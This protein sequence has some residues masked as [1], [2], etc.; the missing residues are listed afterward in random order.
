[1][2]T[3]QGVT[4]VRISDFRRFFT[5]G[6]FLYKKEQ[7]YQMFIEEQRCY[8]AFGNKSDALMFVDNEREF[9]L[10]RILCQWLENPDKEITVST[11]DK[12]VLYVP[13][14]NGEKVLFQLNRL[15]PYINEAKKQNRLTK[16]SI[17]GLTVLYLLLGANEQD[18]DIPVVY[19]LQ[20]VGLQLKDFN[21]CWD[22]VDIEKGDG[23]M[24]PLHRRIFV[25]ANPQKPITVTWGI[26]N[27]VLQP[28][29][30]LI[31]L[32]YGNACHVLL[33]GKITSYQN[34][35]SLRLTADVETKRTRM[36]VHT[37]SD[38]VVYHDDVVSMALANGLPVWATSDGDIRCPDCCYA[39]IKRKEAFKKMKYANDFLAFVQESDDNYVFYATNN[40]N[41]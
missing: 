34:K 29:E 15:V 39:F 41:H 3:M 24:F 36:E 28:K 12:D 5:L 35:V 13:G 33:P 23:L 31:G 10:L 38:G 11:L 7:F 14:K 37:P 9:Y 1:M 4:I 17:L 18:S 20:T 21:E 16:K 30:C 8:C 26:K 2:I 22:D 25:N 40:V 6:E 19:E 27:T 32:F